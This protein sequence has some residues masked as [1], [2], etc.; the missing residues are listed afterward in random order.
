MARLFEEFGQA[1]ASTTRRY[2]GTRLR[3]R[4]LPPAL[5]D[6]GRRH[7]GG[8]AKPGRGTRHDPAR[9]GTGGGARDPAPDHTPVDAGG[10]NRVLVIDDDGA[11][12]DLM[13]RLP[14]R[15]EGFGVGGRR[16]GRPATQR[17]LHP[18]VITLDV[19]MPGMDGSVGLAVKA[20]TALADIPVV[21]L[22]ML[23]GL[24]SSRLRAR[25]RRLPHEK[26]IDRERLVAVLER[27]RRD[28]P[29]TTQLP[30]AGPAAPGAR[31][32]R[33][34]RGRIDGRAALRPAA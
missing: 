8:R 22:A 32:L 23:H 4:P 26:P 2:G 14:C 29:G 16:G 17:E 12:R 7:H 13:A 19:L 27:H 11:V 18:D 10:L 24:G 30:R 5:P 3:P 34:D 25:R 6:D 31:G 15:K 21:M 33:R 20:S 9:G 28:L 1:D